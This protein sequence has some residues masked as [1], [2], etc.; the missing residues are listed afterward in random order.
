MTFAVQHRKAVSKKRIPPFHGCNVQNPTVTPRKASGPACSQPTLPRHGA[1]CNLLQ[2]KLMKS[3][4][5]K[6]EKRKKVLF[7]FY[8]T[9]AH[10]V[11]PSLTSL[12]TKCFF[13]IWNL[14]LAKC[15]QKKHSEI[16]SFKNYVTNAAAAMNN[17]CWHSLNILQ[18]IYRSQQNA[19]RVPGPASE[20]VCST[21]AKPFSLNT[22]QSLGNAWT[23]QIAFSPYLDKQQQPI[24][25][26]WWV[27]LRFLWF[28]SAPLS[29]SNLYTYFRSVTQI[30]VLKL[31]YHSS[32]LPYDYFF[33]CNLHEICL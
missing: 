16:A 26:F 21:L 32:Y 23:F 30:A 33:S 4:W 15:R 6:L 14:L 9:V 8:F 24:N 5:N 29:L 28:L 25:Y 19:Y 7:F 31:A 27:I 2:G 3:Y 10:I 20:L 12:R 17:A 13:C 11:Q 18:I 1:Y 22:I